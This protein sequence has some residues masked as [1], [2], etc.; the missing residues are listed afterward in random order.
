[1]LSVKALLTKILTTNIRSFSSNGTVVVRKA[2]GVVN[3]TYKGTSNAYTHSS[4][5]TVFTLNADECPSE[6][7]VFT[8]YD[9]NTSDVTKTI[10]IGRIET[11]GRVR[12]WVYGNSGTNVAPYFNV[13]FLR[14]I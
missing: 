7:V 3:I 10:L 2:L 12:I 5:N 1:M 4:Y 8:A 13:T 9:N 11:D 14:A 6:E